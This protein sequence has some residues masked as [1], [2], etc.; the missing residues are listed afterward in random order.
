MHVFDAGFGATEEDLAESRVTVDS[1]TVP[2]QK[3]DQW[4]CVS[5]TMCMS[6]T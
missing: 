6:C 1:G 4:K 2:Y 3:D 5:L